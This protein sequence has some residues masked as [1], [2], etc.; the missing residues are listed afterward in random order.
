MFRCY[1]YT[2]IR[3]RINLSLLKLQSAAEQCNTQGGSYMTGTDR[4][5]WFKFM[6]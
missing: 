4:Q 3:E 2:V 6:V 5:L 1:S